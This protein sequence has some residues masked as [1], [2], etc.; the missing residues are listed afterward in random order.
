[1]PWKQES[2]SW[3][4]A[5]GKF[6]SMCNLSVL[7]E[8][9]NYLIELWKIRQNFDNFWK[10]RSTPLKKI[11]D[12]PS[13]S[14][15]SKMG[16]ITFLQIVYTWIRNQIIPFV[17]FF[18]CVLCLLWIFYSQKNSPYLSSFHF[19]QSIFPL[20]SLRISTLSAETNFICSLIV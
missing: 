8:H 3:N 20:L 5:M 19:Y 4:V 7:R 15:I 14:L 18:I 1:M 17:T 6:S 13:R 16:L 11:Q 2:S 10:T 9:E 12:P